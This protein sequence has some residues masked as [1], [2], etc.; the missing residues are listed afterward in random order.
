MIRMSF[1]AQELY[2][3]AIIQNKK[4]MYGIP[5]V[6]SGAPRGMIHEIINVMLTHHLAQMDLDGN[7]SLQEPYAELME[8][9]CDCERCLTIDLRKS[10]SKT[11]S[12]ILWKR[13][14]RYLFAQ[15]VRER[16]VFSEMNEMMVRAL[17]ELVLPGEYGLGELPEV[18]IPNNQ[19]Q[20]SKRMCSR[21]NTA[22]AIRLLRQNGA[23]E[24]AAWV[25]ADGLG[26][27]A[28]ALNMTLLDMT[29][30]ECEKTEAAYLASR[31]HLLALDKAVANQRTCTV[32]RPADTPRMRQTVQQLTARFLKEGNGD[33]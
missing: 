28:Y 14:G 7:T 32:F 16:F 4:T 11:Q 27:E 25:I 20:Q 2:C 10:G 21:D 8:F 24:E 30:G 33:V 23:T 22:D 12:V 1:T 3:M 18:M 17:A 15:W 13:D 31:G 26:E 19:L 9:C 5:D 6:M 29:R